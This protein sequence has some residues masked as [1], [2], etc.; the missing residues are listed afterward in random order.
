MAMRVW[1]ATAVALLLVGAMLLLPAQ[2]AYSRLRDPHSDP[3]NIIPEQLVIVTD[4]GDVF[5]APGC[6]YIQGKNPH[7]IAGS[8]AVARGYAP[9]VRCMEWTIRK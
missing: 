6:K 4:E 2:N 1:A 7:A 3:A 5:H 8:D 9:C